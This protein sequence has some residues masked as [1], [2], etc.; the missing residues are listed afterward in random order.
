MKFRYEAPIGDRLARYF[1][2]VEVDGF[3]WYPHIRQWLLNS[4]PWYAEMGSIRS[5]MATCRTLRAFRRML[6]K[7]PNIRGKARLMSI[8]KGYDVYDS[9]ASVRRHI[10]RVP[11]TLR[12][13]ALAQSLGIKDIPNV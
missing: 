7:Y 6:R 2:G 1:C 10:D 8:Y 4:A 3:T 12:L 13:R 11:M 9:A 5:S